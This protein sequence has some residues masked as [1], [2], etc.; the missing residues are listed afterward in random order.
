M[1]LD[2]YGNIVFIV[3]F[4]VLVSRPE[5]FAATIGRVLDWAYGLLP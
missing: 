3:L 2:R 4:V 1:S 5:I